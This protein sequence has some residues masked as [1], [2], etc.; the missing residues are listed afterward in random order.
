[1]RR[2]FLAIIALVVLLLLIWLPA[3]QSLLRDVLI[4]PLLRAFWIVKLIFESLPQTA[5]W[6]FLVFIALIAAWNGRIIRFENPREFERRQKPLEHTLEKYARLIYQADSDAYARW[7]LANRLAALA[8]RS[9]FFDTPSQLRDWLASEPPELPVELRRY[10]L[11]GL[12]P[13]EPTQR[14]FQLFARMDT[15]SGTAL[16]LDPELV[17]RY[18]EERAEEARERSRQP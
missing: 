15:Q 2:G 14:G 3:S 18:L 12:S 6:F 4:I 10:L 17:V 16:A 8:Q 1:M 7:R 9:F 5:V 13:F 11:A